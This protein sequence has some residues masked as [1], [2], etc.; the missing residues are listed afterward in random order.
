MKD[1]NRVFIDAEKDGEYLTLYKLFIQKKNTG[2]RTKIME[3]YKDFLDKHGGVFMVCLVVNHSFFQK[4][5]WLFFDG[6]QTYEYTK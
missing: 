3:V 2:L 1:G 6:Y 4:F 5:S